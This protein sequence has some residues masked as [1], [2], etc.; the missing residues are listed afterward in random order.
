[1]SKVI[2]F[3]GEIVTVGVDGVVVSRDDIPR[4][5][6]MLVPTSTV[7]EEQECGRRLYARVRVTIETIDDA[8]PPPSETTP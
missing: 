4:S 7:A 6:K 5:S 1:M 3:E 2:E 8:A